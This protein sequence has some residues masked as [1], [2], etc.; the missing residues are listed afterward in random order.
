MS[1]FIHNNLIWITP[2]VSIVLNSVVKIASKP[3]YIRLSYI[4]FL[5]FGFGLSISGILCLITD[6]KDDVGIWLLLSAFILLFVTTVVVHRIGWDS[7]TRK[8]K[9]LGVVIP[10]VIGIMLMILAVLYIGGDIR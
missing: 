10:D 1:Q 5:D 8:Q 7:E 9:I 4:D 3:I 6:V 2:L